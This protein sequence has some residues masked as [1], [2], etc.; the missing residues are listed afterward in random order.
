MLNFKF[1]KKLISTN[2]LLA[3]LGLSVAWL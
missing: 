3:E 1:K 2:E